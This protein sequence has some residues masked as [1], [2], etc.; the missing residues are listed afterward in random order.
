MYIYIE[1][2]TVFSVAQVISLMEM[3]IYIH[4]CIYMYIYIGMY[5]RMYICIYM[6]IEK[7]RLFGSPSNIIVGHAIQIRHH[8]LI[9][10]RY[11]PPFSCVLQCVAVCCRVLQGVAGCCSVLQC[12]AVCCSVLQ[13]VA[14]C[15]S[16]VQ[17]GAVCCSVVQCVAVYCS[18]SQCVAVCC[19]VLQCVAV[20]CSKM[21]LFWSAVKLRLM[22]GT[23]RILSMR[24]DLQLCASVYA[25]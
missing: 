5:T 25:K 24:D 21:A 3:P 4:M 7:H 22:L 6:Y 2:N 12:V 20:C 19:N 18:V 1:R 15:C 10:I 16:V 11:G 9:Q 13:R 17:R 23:C 14:A 8:P